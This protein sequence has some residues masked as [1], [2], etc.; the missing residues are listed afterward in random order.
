MKQTLKNALRNIN[1]Q[2]K[3]IHP[4]YGKCRVML[5][6][7]KSSIRKLGQRQIKA[8]QLSPDNQASWVREEDWRLL[9]LIDWDWEHDPT[10]EERRFLEADI[11]TQ[12]KILGID[13]KKWY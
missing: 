12:K 3:V 11:E 10:G 6:E 9:R 1:G 4:I 7:R 5:V 8:V 2:I 13:G